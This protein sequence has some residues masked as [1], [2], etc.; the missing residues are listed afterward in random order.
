MIFNGKQYNKGSLLDGIGVWK[1]VGSR[2]GHMF[3][4]NGNFNSLFKLFGPEL[5]FTKK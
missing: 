3:E 5:S 4:T 1:F 2:H